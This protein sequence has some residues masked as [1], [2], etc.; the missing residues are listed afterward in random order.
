MPNKGLRAGGQ[1]GQL[2]PLRHH[3]QGA[4]LDGVTQGSSSAVALSQGHLTR[5][6]V[7]LPQRGHDALLLGGPVR[8]RHARAPAVLVR[9]APGEACEHVPILGRR[10]PVVVA[11]GRACEV[12]AA[13]ALAPCEA[14]RGG[15]EGEAPAI[16]REHLRAAIQHVPAWVEHQGD[17]QSHRV[18]N[19]GLGRGTLPMVASPYAAV[20]QGDGDQRGGAGGVHGAAGPE[21][22]QAV[23]E[24]AA[25]DGAALAQSLQRVELA[26][27]VLPHTPRIA[28]EDPTLHTVHGFHVVFC[29]VESLVPRLQDN[30]LRRRHHSHLAWAEP[31][32]DVVKV[33]EPIVGD[34]RPVAHIADAHISGVLAG[35]R[36][37]HV[38]VEPGK[39]HLCVGIRATRVHDPVGLGSQGLPGVVH[40]G[41]HDVHPPLLQLHGD[42]HDLGVFHVGVQRLL[43]DPSLDGRTEVPFWRVPIA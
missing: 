36:V 14:V 9:C 32:L 30:P 26:R 27:A 11:H 25:R 34:E 29:P 8:R 33:Q 23:G 38:N 17:A 10:L 3:P 22:P 5:A 19:V 4:D 35:L 1:N 39:G 6:E 21:E 12:E 42:V 2:P 37:V 28:N 20:R 15:V 31:E 16:R 18:G 43:H 24:P 41:R 7:I 13:T 40:H